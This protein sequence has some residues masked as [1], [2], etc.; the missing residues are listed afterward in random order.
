M[1][2]LETV[3]FDSKSD[4]FKTGECTICMD[5]YTQNETVFR[6]PECKHV[7]HEECLRTWFMSKNQEE[8]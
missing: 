2:V 6:I 7:F 8:E 4:E 1:G 3:C 5:P